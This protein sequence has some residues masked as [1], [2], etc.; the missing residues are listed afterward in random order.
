MTTNFDKEATYILEDENVLLRPLQKDDMP[1]LLPFALN[2]TDTWK[3][4]QISAA[5]EQ[6]MI[7]YIDSAL[8]A[9]A[10]GKEYPFIVY[11]KQTNSYAGCTRFYDIQPV[12]KTLQLGY[13]WYGQKFRG[14]GLNKHCKYLLLQ[15]AF[16]T[17]GMERIEFRAD[18]KNARSIAAMKSIGCQ[19]EGM[20][21][22]HM[23]LADG[24]R[25]DSIVLSI[26][27]NEW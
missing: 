9:K 7:S 21:R 13:T 1:Y 20:I 17:L 24:T 15:F 14:T 5:G 3:Y 22:S 18:A 26:L 2:E 19:V 12:H 8:A 11:D 27:K 6:N 16:E 23:P 25:R 4:S 10:T